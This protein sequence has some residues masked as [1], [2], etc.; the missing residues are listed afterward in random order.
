M[1]M[2]DLVP[3][4]SDPEQG[5]KRHPWRCRAPVGRGRRCGWHNRARDAECRSCGAPYAQEERYTPEPGTQLAE[6]VTLAAALAEYQEL[7]ASVRDHFE[8]LAAIEERLGVLFLDQRD[9]ESITGLDLHSGRGHYSVS[10]D[11]PDDVIEMAERR[12]WS[13]IVER[14]GIRR[15]LSDKRAK[16]IDEQLDRG[17]L[18]PLTMPNVQ[19][20][21]AS[22]QG[23]AE[24]L[25]REKVAEVFNWLRPRSDY[26]TNDKYV[27]GKRV[28]L[29]YMVERADPRWGWKPNVNY[30]KWQILTSLETLFTTMD[31]RGERTKGW[32]SDLHTA[33]NAADP[34]NPVGETTYFRFRACRNG[35]LHLEFRRPDLVAKLN[36]IAG[37]MTLRP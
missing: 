34:E 36:Q 33:I 2:M 1:A 13:A 31:G 3:R 22:A 12:I 5:P 25:L 11:R 7:A 18:P 37:G 28:V 16:E 9:S 6:N 32:K 29:E 24:T 8:Q 35:N 4:Q 19:S 10:F 14:S 30:D 17:P 26:K 27:V 23:S 20:W 15:I 21:I